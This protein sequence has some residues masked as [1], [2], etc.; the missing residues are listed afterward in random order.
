MVKLLIDKELLLLAFYCVIQML[1]NV[2]KINV[3]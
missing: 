2:A 1:I 3:A